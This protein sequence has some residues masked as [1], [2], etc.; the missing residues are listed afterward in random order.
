MKPTKKTSKKVAAKPVKKNSA[1]AT[2]VREKTY[3]IKWTEYAD[4]KCVMERTSDGFSGYELLGILGLTK[5]EIVQ[6]IKGIIKPDL[7][8]RQVLID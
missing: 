6:Q 2:V 1:S 8:K 7:I 3:T 4:G 5:D